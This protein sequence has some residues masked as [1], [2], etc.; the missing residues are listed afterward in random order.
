[1]KRVYLIACFALLFVFESPVWPGFQAKGEA[2]PPTAPDDVTKNITS[3]A[4]EIKGLKS[5]NKAVTTAV[6]SL[7]AALVPLRD[8]QDPDYF[9]LIVPYLTNYLKKLDT[10]KRKADASADMNDLWA[11]INSVRGQ[12]PA[13]A[14]PSLANTLAA[15]L[16]KPMGG[17]DKAAVV[18]SITPLGLALDKFMSDRGRHIHIISARYGDIGNGSD[19]R[20][21]DATA[22]FVSA[23]EGKSSCP[24]APNATMITGANVCGYEPAPLEP[25][26]VNY[27]E[28]KYR[29]ISFDL[30]DAAADGDSSKDSK[31]AKLYSKDKIV[32]L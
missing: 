4:A 17:A 2:P 1:M 27:A 29:C 14:I 15:D 28:V 18:K 21:C 30:P 10:D 23:C 9:K 31:T 7:D 3:L 19:K 22:Y 11:A 5:G 20:V 26:G 24:V 32:C 12:S 16:E 8:P 13:A 6:K 25:D